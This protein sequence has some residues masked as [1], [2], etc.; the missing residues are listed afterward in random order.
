MPVRGKAECAESPGNL[1]KIIQPVWGGARFCIPS[2]PPWCPR[3]GGPIMFWVARCY[4]FSL[5]ISFNT[6]N[7]TYI[8]QKRKQ[9]HTHLETCSRSA[10]YLSGRSGVWSWACSVPRATGA[11]WIS[12]TREMEATNPWSFQLPSSASLSGALLLWNR[13][14]QFVFSLFFKSGKYKT[15]LEK[16][17][18]QVW[19][20]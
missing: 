4:S 1:V 11:L 2:G 17:V 10:E 14:R 18:K 9:N 5:L 7:R 13:V 6:P 3:C 15:L 20:W 19:L 8:F 16:C 12:L